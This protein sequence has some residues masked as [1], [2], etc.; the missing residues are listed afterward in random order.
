MINL[1]EE[2]KVESK[3]IEPKGENSD[4]IDL[5]GSISGQINVVIDALNDID[6]ADNIIFQS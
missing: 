2:K 5:T 3:N 4:F 1:P 6:I